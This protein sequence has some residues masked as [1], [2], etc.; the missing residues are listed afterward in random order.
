MALA[1]PQVTETKN[2][3]KITAVSP[4][5]STAE[6]VPSGRPPPSER[7]LHAVQR[8]YMTLQ[9]LFFSVVSDS[10]AND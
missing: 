8:A 4:G 6:L 9:K 3:T 10:K 2:E 7:D 1:S 5:T